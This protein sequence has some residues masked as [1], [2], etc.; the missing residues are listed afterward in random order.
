MPP[1]IAFLSDIGSADEAHALC[2]GLMHT[3]APDVT[4]VDL[5][6]D[7]TAFDVR[8]GALFLADVPESFPASAIIC[9][10]VYPETGTDTPTI[11][12][13]NTK[14]QILVAPNNGLLTFA[15]KNVPAEEC[16]EVKS[17]DVMHQPVTPTW[18]GKDIV[19]ACAAHIAAGVPIS[20]VGPALEVEKITRL[21]YSE[22]SAFE[23]GARGEVVRIDKT[24]GNVWTNVTLDML[25]SGG[26]FGRRL[27]VEFGDVSVELPFCRTFGDVGVGEPLAYVNSRGTFAFGVNQG[28]FLDVWAVPPGTAFTVRVG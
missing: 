15:L 13:R 12:V 23:G 24:F 5:T 27:H 20:D 10:Y 21:P 17:T 4:I 25:G 9:A 16:Y 28:S 22:P 18:Y 6:H 8:E 7:V 11:V 2:K 26:L 14:G 1:L 3:I 19:S